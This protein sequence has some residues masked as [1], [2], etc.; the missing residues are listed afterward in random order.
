MVKA[1]ANSAEGV[2]EPRGSLRLCPQMYADKKDLCKKEHQ[3]VH[4]YQSKKSK[5]QVHSYISRGLL[6]EGFQGPKSYIFSPTIA[7]DIKVIVLGSNAKIAVARAVPLVQDFFYFKAPIPQEKA[8][9]ALI[10][11]IA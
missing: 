7:Q 11:F 1:T 2:R 6:S 5:G 10:S 4:S 8:Q 9:W 3:V